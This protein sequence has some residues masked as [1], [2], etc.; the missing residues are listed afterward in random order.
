MNIIFGCVCVCVCVCVRVRMCVCYLGGTESVN[1]NRWMEV[2]QVSRC[3]WTLLP[4]ACIPPAFPDFDLLTA[5]IWYTNTH[6]HTHARTDAS[7][8]TL[9]SLW[10]FPLFSVSPSYMSVN[11]KLRSSIIK[12][13]K[14]S[15]K[16]KTNTRKSTRGTFSQLVTIIPLEVS[17]WRGG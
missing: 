16:N 11:V 15:L 13:F 5:P 8:R 1:I 14:K 12:S 9:H 2:S 6:T 10:L 7:A 3:R 4:S 17:W